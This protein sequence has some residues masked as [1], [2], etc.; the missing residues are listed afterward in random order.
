MLNFKKV[1]GVWPESVILERMMNRRGFAYL[2]AVLIL[3]LLAFMGMFLQ[4]SSSAEYSQAA[5]SVYRTMA[6]QLA[7]AAADEAC[8]LLE[9]RFRDKTTTGFLQQLLWQASTSQTPKNGGSTGLNPTLL[10]DFTDLK[11]KVTQVLTLKDYHMTRAGFTIEKILPNIKDCRPIPQG[12]L[13]NP[14]NY[15]HSPDRITKFDD[16]YAKDWYLTL[17]LEVT[18]SLEK[19]RK[20]KIDYTI[21]RDIKLLN[22][23][24]IARNYSLFSIIGH[25][26]TSSDPATVQGIL[27]NEMNTPDAAGGRLFLWNMPFQSRVYMHGPSIIALE[28]PEMASD[29]QNRGAFNIYDPKY[30]KPGNNQA[31]QYNDTFFGMSYFPTVG[32]AIFPS[33]SLWDAISV[34]WRE[35]KQTKDDQAA[36]QTVYHN[37][38]THKTVYGGVM[39]HQNKTLLEILGDISGGGIQDTYY[40]GT[41][42]H[43]KFMPGG[44]FCR[45]PWKYVSNTLM[46]EDRYLP[47][48]KADFDQAT[49]KVFPKDDEHLRLEHRW[50]KDDTEVAKQTRIYSRI[51]E[52]KYNNVTNGITKPPAEKHLEFSLSYFNDPDPEGFLS[53]LGYAA[54]A[55][56]ESFW[57]SLTLPFEAIGVLASPLI[58]KIFGP[59]DGI[60]LNPAEQ[61]FPNL[62]PTNFKY[63]YRALVTRKLKDE[64]EIP[65][66]AEGRWLLN[67]VYWLDSFQVEAPVVYV[68][69]GTIM[70][71]RFDAARPFKIKGSIIALKAEDKVTPLG[72]LNLFYHPY[73]PTVTDT[74][75][76]AMIIE[77]SGNLIEASVF[78]CYGIRTT[79]GNIA[80]LTKVGIYPDQPTDKWD[81]N[82]LGKIAEVSNIIFGNYVNFFMNKQFQEGDLWVFHNFNNPLYFEKLGAGYRIVQDSLDASE[83]NRKKYELM[84]H[85]FFLSPKIQH[86]ASIGGGDD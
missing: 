45:T 52:I 84:T 28:N 21:S 83:D 35:G 67:G 78:S 63:N 41:N 3:G 80:D 68:G 23:G 60:A 70:V 43:Q 13:D 30:P 29:F 86:V 71:T 18:V 22:M 48:S 81:P 64:G 25:Q 61:N 85:E 82:C 1:C 56:G 20:I 57:N 77:G 39:P 54:G 51:Y 55:V 19:R 50:H 17:Q 62:F 76:R 8:V 42:V 9:E 10:H 65:R 34:W 59:G 16:Q 11:D 38:Y 40:K 44:P 58:S 53:K 36:N 37:L 14:D 69:T 49:K 24:P 7:E 4:Q 15:H 66:D 31:F 32:R 27:R 47:N 26:L 5:I 73:L 2:V 46:G 79:D 72:H 6:R 74:R 75:E 33:K 12:P